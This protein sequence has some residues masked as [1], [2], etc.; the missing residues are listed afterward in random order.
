MHAEPHVLHLHSGAGLY[1]AEYVLLGLIPALAQQGIDGSLLCLDNHLLDEQ[2]LYQRA[3]ALK[4]P[5]QRLPCRGRFDFATLRALR[6]VLGQHPNA[7]LHV[8]GY[9]SAFY[10]WLARRAGEPSIVATLHGHFADTP[11]MRIYQALELWLMRGFDRVCMVAAEMQPMLARAGVAGQNIS[12]IENGVDTTRFR[13]DV[14]PLERADCGIPEDAFVF[15][16]A[17]RL[18]EQKHP[19]GLLDAFAMLLKHAPR[20]WLVLAGDGPLHAT[21]LAHACNLGIEGHVRLLGARNDLERFYP[22]LDCFVLASLYE[23]LP[24]ALL[25]A[26]AA[27]RPLISSAVGQVPEV[28]SGLP[29]AL[30]P[31]RDAVALAAAMHE[32]FV[33]GRVAQPALRQRVIERYSVA[34]MA[35]DYAALYRT[36]WNGDRYAMA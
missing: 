13:P 34:R 12:L 22:M 7:M 28:L 36:L 27:A 21:V 35:R 5:S 14:A 24:L 20:S 16:S 30:V 31:P 25:E 4:I 1:G 18:S 2:P 23:G 11:S 10:A 33:G 29:A 32:A 17:M 3:C 6:R 15:G 9:K 26:M 19:L 8:H